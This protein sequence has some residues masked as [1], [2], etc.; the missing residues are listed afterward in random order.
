M[1]MLRIL[2]Y[3]LVTLLFSLGGQ[4]LLKKGLTLILAGAHPTPVQFVTQYLGRVLASP[5][6]W[7]GTATSGVG[8]FCFI[9]ILSRFQLARALPIMGGIA[10]VLM[11]VIGRV[12]FRESTSWWNFA[13]I[14]LIICGLYL[15]TMGNPEA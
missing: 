7:L 11:F 12:C 14:V 4:S 13:G 8:F 1:Y 3:F 6:F 2:P 5:Y 15:V 9:F 10:Y